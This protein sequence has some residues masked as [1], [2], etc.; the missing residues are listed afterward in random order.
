MCVRAGSDRRAQRD[1][2]AEDAELAQRDA[3]R[4]LWS[5]RAVSYLRAVLDS[6]RHGMQR[7]PISTRCFEADGA[8]GLDLSDDEVEQLESF[9]ATLTDPELTTRHEWSAP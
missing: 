4:T 5:R 2:G 6:Y 7:R 9:L 1:Q 3:Q 8:I